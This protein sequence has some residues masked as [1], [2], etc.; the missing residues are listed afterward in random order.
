MPT[1]KVTVRFKNVPE[2]RYLGGALHMRRGW[3]WWW[4]A[5][6]PTGEALVGVKHG[7]FESE[8]IAMKDARGQGASC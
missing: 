2:D 6:A 5:D 3:Y 4:H 8:Y 1:S 7:P